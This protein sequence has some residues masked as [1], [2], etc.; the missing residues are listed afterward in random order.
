MAERIDNELHDLEHYALKGMEYGQLTGLSI[1]SHAIR[2]GF[3]LMHVGV[4]CKN[5]AVAHLM[6]HDAVEDA[7]LRE[8]WTE[9]GDRDLILGASGRAAPYMRSWA[10]RQEPAVM[11]MTSVTFIDLAGEDLKDHIARAAEDLPFPVLFVPTPGVGGDMFRGYASAMDA[12]LRKMN[13]DDVPPVEKQV[14]LLGYWFDRYEQDHSANLSHLKKLLS[15]LGLSLGPSLF[16]GAEYDT[17]LKFPGNELIVD[18]PYTLPRRKAI[19]RQ[20]KKRNLVSTDLPI[21]LN[22]TSRW[23]RSVAEAAGTWSPT[24]Q[25][26][27]KRMEEAT[28]NRIGVMV[29]RWRGMKVAVFADPAH[30]AGLTSLLLEL[31]I[32]PVI[33]GLKGTTMGGEEQ[34]RN[35][36]EADGNPLPEDCILLDNPSVDAIQTH[37][38][39]RLERK[40]LDG[41][42]G[43]AVDMN[44][45]ASLPESSFRRGTEI[46]FGPFVVETGFPCRDHH[47]LYPL[48]FMGYR[49]VEAW[50]QRILNAPRLWN[51]G[52]PPMN[53]G[54]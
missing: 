12:I 11:F 46:P 52:K 44:A 20:C 35:C 27:I 53:Q 36:L 2:D 38:K 50:V 17:L 13:W 43:N 49:G 54:F 33:V 34:F 1:A 22:G 21:G 29:D 14:G 10:Q 7:N 41:V 42:F 47:V 15:I 26:R 6:T 28:R 40:E 18:L 31:G 19:H 32:Q 16:N 23:L 3:L 5:K 24:V 25:L 37:L 8:G 51:G 9:V 48:P 39:T 45:L 4:G 30:G